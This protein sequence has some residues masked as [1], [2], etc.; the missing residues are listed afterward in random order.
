M[1]NNKPIFLWPFI[2]VYRIVT[3]VMKFPILFVRHFCL[4]FFFT[5]CFFIEQL[6]TLFT[7]LFKYGL[8]GLIFLCYIVY[9]AV[10][11]IFKALFKFIRYFLLGLSFPFVAVYKSYNDESAKEKRNALKEMKAYQNE[12]VKQYKKI[13]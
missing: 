13:S 7:V 10:K 9:A 3:F 12:I 5:V 8:L 4:G 1:I 11:I 2:L 6:V